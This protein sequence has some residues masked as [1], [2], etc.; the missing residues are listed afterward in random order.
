MALTLELW[1]AN[2]IVLVS[3]VL[4]IKVFRVRG[5]AWSYLIGCYFKLSPNKKSERWKI[6]SAKVVSVI[7]LKYW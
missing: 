6:F 1:Q 5:G 3:T 7:A 4:A 2:L